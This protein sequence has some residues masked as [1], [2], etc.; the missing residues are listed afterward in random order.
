MPEPHAACYNEGMRQAVPSPIIRAVV[1]PLLDRVDDIVELATDKTLRSFRATGA[2]QSV[3]VRVDEDPSS[4]R[5]AREAFVLDVLS[6][7][8]EWSGRLAPT[9]LHQGTLTG[10]DGIER[11][12]I[13]YPWVHGV[14]LDAARLASRSHDVGF[15]FALLHQTRADDLD[16]LPHDN[17]T[18]G[19]HFD[20][21]VHST[22]QWMAWREA[23]GLGQDALTV[24]LH[25]L[26]RLL[27]P[28]I[29]AQDSWSSTTP[30]VLC[31]GQ[32]R[33]SLVL[34]HTERA[35]L[36]P[37]VTLVGFDNAHLGDGAAEL[38]NLAVAAKLDPHSE[39]GLLRGYRD[40][41][42]HH[43]A[44]DDGF[45]WRYHAHRR[46][47]LLA[48]PLARLH[49]MWAIKRGQHSTLIDPLTAIEEETATAEQ[50]LTFALN[51]LRDFSGR[52]RT[53]T[54]AEMGTLGRLVTVEDLVLAGRSFHLAFSGQP[55]AG[56]TEVAA[57]VAMRLQHAF[58]STTGLSRALAFVER[59]ASPNRTAGELVRALFERGF[60]MTPQIEPPFYRASFD[61]EEQTAV[62]HDEANLVVRAGELLDDERMRTAL[63]DEL[64]RRHP[65]G[66][67]VVEGAYAVQL[68]PG[69]V[70][71]FH[72]TQ[73]TAVRTS[74][75]MH[76]R[77]DIEDESA[78]GVVLDSLDQGQPPPPRDAVVIH[79]NSRPAASTAL[80]VLMRL[81]PPGRKP[82]VD[83]SSR[84]PLAVRLD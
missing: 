58:F 41:A 5:I 28:Y 76:H 18:I 82:S 70:H 47:A 40:A 32:P 39:D 1:E 66:G 24:Q 73:D 14:P 72:L 31:H 62:L 61:G 49:R 50:E 20:D 44:H 53:I 55:Y 38:A 59:D 60:I 26:V 75:F 7:Q 81:L 25:D 30:M 21:L 6:E 8:T 71:S 84:P 51:E 63:R 56:K 13:A 16:V 67:M 42:R 10:I 12:C 17:R 35:P 74:R 79:A 57:T 9:L 77:S 19:Q 22:E 69:R 34:A 64:A 29:H 11:D 23:D 46:I 78:A 15:A 48:Q 2:D 52:S 37:R 3:V 54:V 65:G 36:P 80:Q 43:D 27:T 33:P 83:L 45:L 4:Q 68:L